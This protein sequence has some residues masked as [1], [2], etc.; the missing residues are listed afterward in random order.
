MFSLF[1]RKAPPVPPVPRLEDRKAR[2]S[3]IF[4]TDDG[5][6]HSLEVVGE[7]LYIQ[8]HAVMSPEENL[9]HRLYKFRQDVAVYGIT[10]KGVQ[11]LPHQIKRIT[12]S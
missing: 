3:A 5:V 9:K 11:Y 4:L 10:I 2:A 1:R 8:G 6:E 7:T 12:W